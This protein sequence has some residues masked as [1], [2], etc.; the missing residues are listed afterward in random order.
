[1]HPLAPG[2]GFGP[3]PL[4]LALAQ[5]CIRLLRLQRR[6]R[7]SLP[8]LLSL[9]QEEDTMQA[10]LLPAGFRPATS[11]EL[12]KVDGGA[13]AIEYGLIAA[14]IAVAIIT[15]VGLVGTNLNTTF[16]GIQAKMP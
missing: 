5:L 14:G 15:A 1:R 12:Q 11:D 4:A 16:A 3:D 2:A 6:E 10:P 7:C 9:I 13:T 8:Q